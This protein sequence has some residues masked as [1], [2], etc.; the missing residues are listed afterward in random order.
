MTEL[1]G[2]HPAHFALRGLPAKVLPGSSWTQTLAGL[3]RQ[4]HGATRDAWTCVSTHQALWG[5][6]RGGQQCHF[7]WGDLC[8]GTVGAIGINSAGGVGRGNL[9]PSHITA[10]VP[11]LQQPGWGSRVTPTPKEDALQ[12]LSW[13]TF[14]VTITQLRDLGERSGTW[15]AAVTGLDE[16]E[17]RLTS[18]CPGWLPAASLQVLDVPRGREGGRIDSPISIWPRQS[19][20]ADSMLVQPTIH[21]LPC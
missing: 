7:L 1:G 13:L 3:K 11:W 20:R 16:G 18:Q 6:T 14:P 9:F 8:W 2:S 15:P 10:M 19:Y 12:P 21:F 5:A 17:G 4:K